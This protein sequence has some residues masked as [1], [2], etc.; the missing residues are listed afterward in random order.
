MKNK[1]ENISLYKFYFGSSHTSERL[2]LIVIIVI[3]LFFSFSHLFEDFIF[4]ILMDYMEKSE[5]VKLN[6]ACLILIAIGLINGLQDI[7]LGFLFKKHGE[8]FI[9]SYKNNYYSLV[10]DQDYQ[11]FVKKDL[12]ELSESIKNDL[13][14]I[15]TAVSH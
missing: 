3:L 11:W 5:L 14:N 13:T 8:K 1:Y 4:G 9:N 7:S 10:L 6:K 2:I 15:E 12:N